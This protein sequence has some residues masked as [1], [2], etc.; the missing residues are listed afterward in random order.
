MK[1]RVRPKAS[2]W[3]IKLKHKTHLIQSC[4]EVSV[5]KSLPLCREAGT[6][7][8]LS[9]EERICSMAAPWFFS[10]IQLLKFSSRS[11]WEWAEGSAL[12]SPVRGSRPCAYG[13]SAWV[14]P[15]VQILAPQ[16]STSPVASGSL[17]PLFLPAV[18]HL[19]NGG[20]NSD[21]L[22]VLRDWSDRARRRG[23]EWALGKCEPCRVQ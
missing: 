15:W 19:R 6:V 12:L 17:L 20:H 1:C 9:K 13:L 8:K 11:V 23:L 18:S 10:C 5:L 22:Q 7:C 14:F 3:V 21:C 4:T 2:V 16:T